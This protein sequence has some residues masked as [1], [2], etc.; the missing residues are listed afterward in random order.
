MIYSV[1]NVKSDLIGSE[2]KVPKLYYLAKT[3]KENIT[4]RPTVNTIDIF[5]YKLAKF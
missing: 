3:H 1:K 2:Y 5:C 4:L